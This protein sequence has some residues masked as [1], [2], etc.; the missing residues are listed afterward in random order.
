MFKIVRTTNTLFRSRLIIKG[1]K[2]LEARNKFVDTDREN[3]LDA[4]EYASG[5]FNSYKPG[6]YAFVGQ[7]WVNVKTLDASVLAHV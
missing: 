2:T 5:H 3:W 6:T 1:F 7:Q 4:A